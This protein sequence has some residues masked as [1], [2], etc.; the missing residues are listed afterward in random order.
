MY[1]IKE[2]DESTVVSV[3]LLEKDL[4]LPVTLQIS[5]SD[6]TA[7]KYRLIFLCTVL[8]F[9]IMAWNSCRSRLCSFIQADDFSN[10]F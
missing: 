4:G 7:S 2:N 8:I 1:F 9:I 6:L 5:T 10:W 3:L